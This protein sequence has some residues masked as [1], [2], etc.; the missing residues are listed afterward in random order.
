M[1]WNDAEYVAGERGENTTISPQAHQDFTLDNWYGYEGETAPHGYS[2][3][4]RIKLTAA[5]GESFM[6]RRD[7]PLAYNPA[8]G[9]AIRNP[10]GGQGAGDGIFL[11]DCQVTLDR[12][13]I[14]SATGCGVGGMGGHDNGEH[15]T[16]C[17]IESQATGNV[18]AV[19]L[20]CS[21][22]VDNCLIIGSGKAGLWPK[23]PVRLSRSTIVAAKPC[24]DSVGLISGIPW[25]KAWDGE[26]WVTD[27][28]VIGWAHAAGCADHKFSPAWW[29]PKSANN[30][31]DTA[32][33]SDHP[34]VKSVGGWK[35]TIDP[36][37]GKGTRYKVP[38][39]RTTFVNP[40]TDWRVAP[41]SPLRGLGMSAGRA[42][43]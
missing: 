32:E 19:E 37:P 17:I 30:A 35:L 27:T 28:I 18:A 38:Y 25:N 20:D 42:G 21:C 6:D 8:N 2:G 33:T 5:P 4:F 9:V 23:Y 29:N 1:L 11:H 15:L 24:A 22:L 10:K 34:V 12:L 13:Q 41:D 26:T 31:T 7:R 39:D 16:D 43:N 40:G 36:L 3:K 14:Q